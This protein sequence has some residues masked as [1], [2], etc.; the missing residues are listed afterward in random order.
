MPNVSSLAVA[1]MVLATTAGLSSCRATRPAAAAA[2][3]FYHALDAQPFD[4]SAIA[5]L[6]LPGP[7]NAEIAQRFGSL[8]SWAGRVTKNGI[9]WRAEVVDEAPE[10]D[11]TRIDLVVL[12]NDGT[13]RRDRLILVE[14]D[15]HWLVDMRTVAR[16][17]APGP[18]E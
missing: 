9:M 13:R 15:G 5:A 7:G 4:E 18:G 6:V 16:A 11:R 14:Q 3:S 8:E 12:F 17:L 2:R 10:G 1:V